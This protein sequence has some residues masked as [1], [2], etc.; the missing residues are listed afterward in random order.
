[1]TYSIVAHDADTGSFGV[2][3]QSHWFAVGTVVPWA[4]AGVGAV[5]TQAH[6]RA[7]YGPELLGMLAAGASAPDALR[8]AVAGDDAAE[9]RQVAVVDAAGR[10][11]VHTGSGCI[12]EAGHEVDEDNHVAAQANIMRGPGVPA[13]MLDA[14]R[15]RHAEHAPLG[16][17]LVAALAAAERAGG[18]L[19]GRQSAALLIVGSEGVDVDLRVDDHPDPVAELARLLQLQRAYAE[20]EHGDEAVA[21]GDDQAAARAYAAA[22]EHAP[23]HPEVAFWAALAPAMLGDVDASTRALGDLPDGDGR[24]AELLRRL[25][26]AGLIDRD[27]LAHLLPGSMHLR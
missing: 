21:A 13:A 10:V 25:G 20:L 12:A 17:R 22:L 15:Q 8:D 3:V 5:A 14:Y 1:M 26:D 7:E 9:V 27:Q 4:R 24:W 11:A 18:D 2:A 23:E 6:A 16:A 19:R